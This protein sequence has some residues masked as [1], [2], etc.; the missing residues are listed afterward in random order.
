VVHGI[1][2][3]KTHAKAV[4]VVRREAHGLRRYVHIGTGNYNSKT[5]RNYEDVGIFTC[6]EAISADV[7]DLF[8]SLTGMARAPRYRKV[9]VSPEYTREGIIDEIRRCTEAGPGARIRMKMN[10]LVDRSCIRALYEASQAGVQVDLCVRGICRLRPG[11]EGVS[12]NIRVVSVVGR[13][14][15]HS[16][17][18]GFERGEE[19]R[20]WLGSADL[21]PRNLDNRVELLTPVEDPAIAA[22]LAETLD[23]SLEDDT[24]CW[25]L[26]PDGIWNPRRAGERALHRE[27]MERATERHATAD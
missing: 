10:A 24:F 21:M 22:Y 11:V 7:A 19:T 3:L 2:G 17:I 14:L 5:A 15:E 8:N 1:P 26:G 18:Y 27:L 9:L 23:R 13:F 12:E 25:E 20:W 16:R 6:D 4:L